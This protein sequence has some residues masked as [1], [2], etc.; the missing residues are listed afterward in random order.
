MAEKLYRIGN[1]LVTKADY[2]RVSAAYS[3]KMRAVPAHM[4]G[5]DAI[6][7]P[8]APSTARAPSK[9]AGIKYADFDSDCLLSGTYDRKTGDMT[10]D[11]VKGGSW[12]YAGVP[13]G[14]WNDLTTDGSPGT[15]FN[16]EVR[17]AFED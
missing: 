8:A 17:G 15:V 1:H 12:D 3:A 10:L 5:I 16:D 11:F 4:K 6:G 13:L 9:A 7:K 2:A 14:V